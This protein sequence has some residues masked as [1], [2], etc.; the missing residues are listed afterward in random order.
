V[1]FFAAAL[2]AV[3]L[4]EQRR[5]RAALSVSARDAL[6]REA[7]RANDA[8]DA[9]ETLLA[10]GQESNAAARAEEAKDASIA[11]LDTVGAT[12]DFSARLANAATTRDK[13]DAASGAVRF[14]ARGWGEPGGPTKE[15]TYRLGALLVGFAIA[16]AIAGK[17]TPNPIT[18]RASTQFYDDWPERTIDGE[19]RTNWTTEE[20][21]WLELRLRSARPVAAV[22]MYFPAQSSAPSVTITALDGSNEVA[23]ATLSRVATGWNVVRLHAAEC[24]RV[25]LDV[26]TANGRGFML[27]EVELQ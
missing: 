10:L 21:G 11:M 22:A 20:P 26:S 13:L 18:V 27:G 24:N 1:K 17:L 5:A 3:L 8:C 25:R 6:R 7:S 12:G 2:D 14:V 9:A 23:H 16:L 19:P 4:D 15:R